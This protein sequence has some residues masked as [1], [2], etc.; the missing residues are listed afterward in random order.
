VSRLMSEYQAYLP[1]L[2]GRGGWGLS[3]VS[4]R[5]GAPGASRGLL[6][7][8]LVVIGVGAL[9]LYV[10]APDVQRYLKMRDM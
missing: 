10:L 4:P 5:A 9:A 1:Q 7:A 8:G 2:G 3:P 6:V